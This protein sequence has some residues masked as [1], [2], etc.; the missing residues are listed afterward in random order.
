MKTARTGRTSGWAPWALV[1]A[2][3]LAT[4]GGT[5]PAIAE[6]T[7]TPPS[8]VVPEVPEV[9]AVPHVPEPPEP[10][11][12]PS[13][14]TA[15][16]GSFEVGKG[17]VHKGNA[18]LITPSVRIDGTLAGDLFAIAASADVKGKIQGDVGFVGR[19]FRLDG[20][21]DDAARIWAAD[22]RIDGLVDGELIASGAKIVIGPKGVVR[23]SA[24]LYASEIIVE[25]TVDGD[26]I[27]AGGVVRL[28]GKVTG[29]ASVTCDSFDVEKGARIE[30][31]LDYSSR[32]KL[33][34]A[35]LSP[36]VGGEVRFDEQ[37]EVESTR[38][39]PAHEKL[40]IE[41][42]DGGSSGFG[43]RI[44]AFFAALVVGSLALR[45]FRGAAPTVIGYVGTDPL[46]SLGVG[47]LTIL[48]AIAAVF[49]VI[50]I[51]TI[52]L[53]LIYWLLLLIAFY[54]GKVPVAVWIGRWGLGKLGRASSSD[55]WSFVA[56]LFVLYVVFSIPI[57]GTWL[58]FLVSLLGLG[59]L[60]LGARDHRLA[61]RSPEP[62]AR[63]AAS[64]PPVPPPAPDAPAG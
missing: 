1:A 44:F 16:A 45:A 64:P 32:K 53:V 20:Q 55:A 50:L 26:L 23:G 58:W 42:A 27:A 6:T 11:S 28:A 14:T 38:E 22:V 24:S 61:R 56:G 30:G 21:V 2:L 52:P 40:R 54:L 12:P 49:A 31:D 8:P 63:P 13:G 33:D 35:V 51:I 17:E 43:T 41:R 34:T 19:S 3:A 15:L 25:G 60:V 5:V 36:V 59:A 48:S 29:E 4:A 62:A 7:E 18:Y 37:V 10:P 57:L 47:F 46:K 39:R 9:P